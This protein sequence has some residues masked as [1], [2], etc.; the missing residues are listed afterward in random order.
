MPMTP[1]PKRR[2]NNMEDK[3]MDKE[4]LAALVDELLNMGAYAKL[5]TEA[6]KAIKNALEAGE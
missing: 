5:S 3:T 6:R 4:Q 1:S 2:G